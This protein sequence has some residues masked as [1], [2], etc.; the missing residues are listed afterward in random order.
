MIY[1][2]FLNIVFHA[3]K[4]RFQLELFYYIYYLLYRKENTTIEWDDGG[5]KVIKIN[6]NSNGIY[7]LEP[8]PF[9]AFY[10]KDLIFFRNQLYLMWSLSSSFFT[11]FFM[12][13]VFLS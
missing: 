5:K 7:F 10:F 8:G 13:G 11:D 3:P 12:L 6:N 2:Y 4:G 9:A 1:Q